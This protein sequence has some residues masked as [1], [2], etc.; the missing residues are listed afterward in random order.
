MLINP[1]A[2]LIWAEWP[3]SATKKNETQL[4]GCIGLVDGGCLIYMY[5][6]VWNEC[7]TK[8]TL[9]DT[10]GIA[11]HSLPNLLNYPQY[12]RIVDVVRDDWPPWWNDPMQIDMPILFSY[13][14]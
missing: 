9:D 10:V 4:A 13:I 2:F 11:V 3:A 12:Y 6:Y 7:Y 1:D 8:V 14:C 5:D